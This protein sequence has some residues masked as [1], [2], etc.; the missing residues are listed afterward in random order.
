MHIV[1]FNLGNLYRD[2]GRMAEA[3]KA[4]S[5]ALTICREL[6]A[7]NP[8][9]YRRYVAGTLNNLGNLYRHRPPGRGRQCLQ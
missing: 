5:E 1:D 2:T 6:A 3:D 8:D 4:F 7:H 9:A